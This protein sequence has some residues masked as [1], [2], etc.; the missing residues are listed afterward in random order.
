MFI[1][2]LEDIWFSDPKSFNQK[3]TQSLIEYSPI[4]PRHNIERLLPVQ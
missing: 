3:L 2:F 1:V 4:E